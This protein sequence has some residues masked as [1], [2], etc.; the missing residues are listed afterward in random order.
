VLVLRG[1]LDRESL[2]LAVVRLKTAEQRLGWLADHLGELDG[3]GIIYCLTVA[4]TQEIADFLR[5]RGHTVAAYSG[6][7]ETGEREALESDLAAGRVKA[8]VATSALGMGF[9]ATLGFVINVG[10]PSSPVA[11]YQQVGRAGRG[12]DKAQVVLLPAIEDRDIWKYFASLAFPPEGQ[13]RQVLSVLDGAERPLGTPSLETYVDLGRSRL[14]MMLKVLD[15]DGAVQRVQGG[16]QSTGRAWDY[17][18][19]RY[20]R[21]REAREREQQAMLDYL[22]TDRCRMLFL[23]DQL[24]DPEA[25][26]CGRCDN[27]G[28]LTVSADVSEQAQEAAHERLA[29]PGVVVEARKMWPTALTNLGIELKGKIADPPSAG[30]AVARLTDLGYG[31][32]LRDLF[33]EGTPDGP[34][35]VPLV[36]AVIEVLG[37][38]KPRAA[39]IVFVE[40]ARRPTL[41]SDFA[42]GLSRYLR[43]PVAGRFAI[44]D[45]GVAPG[46]GAANSAQRVAAVLRRYR[47]E[48]D[49][50]TGPVLL[51]DDLVGTGWTLTVA[52]RAL[53][54]AGATDVLPLTLGTET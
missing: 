26:A 52:S 40:S 36:K 29:R 2:H 41:T 35:P 10:A 17:D 21:V 33:R 9:D 6:Q 46:Q 4:Q 54:E 39:A 42:D 22:S 50:P 14:E 53:R 3:S 7:T 20:D 1:S 48:A 23:R 37:D 45:P 27:C 32:Q 31:Q 34:V 15:V 47:L 5:A 19:D 43:I 28:G 11:Y 49:L 18:Q 16:W 8:L 51:L 25:A 44:A 30:R 13:V 12:T 38:W 24:D